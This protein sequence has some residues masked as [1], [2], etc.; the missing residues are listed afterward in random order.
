MPFHYR[1]DPGAEAAVHR[2]DG[3]PR[4][5]PARQLLAGGVP[6]VR[7]G[8]ELG[9]AFAAI[10]VIAEEDGVVHGDL[11]VDAVWITGDGAVSL[12]GYVPDGRRQS[13]AP[14]GVPRGPSTDRYGLGRLLARTLLANAAR[15]DEA[16]KTGA[17]A[18]DDA[19]AAMVM[20]A[21]VPGLADRTVNDLRWYI[22]HLLS[23]DRAERPEPLAVWQSLEAF[24]RTAAGP[25]LAAWATAAHR[26]QADVRGPMAPVVPDDT[27]AAPRARGAGLLSGVRFS[28][29]PSTTLFWKRDAAAANASDAAAP[30]TPAPSAGAD[31]GTGVPTSD[32]AS[33]PNASAVRAAPP[34]PGSRAR[35]TAEVHL[36][37]PEPGGGER[38]GHWS[39]GELRAM[40]REVAEGP[41]PRRDAPV[42]SDRAR[43]AASAVGT[44]R[45]ARSAAADR[46]P[47]A[48][49]VPV[50]SAAP[51]AGRRSLRERVGARVAEA[52]AMPQTPPA[53]T[54]AE[55]LAPSPSPG[56]RALHARRAEAE[57]AQPSTPV[58]RPGRVR[59]AVSEEE[60]DALP[61]SVVALLAVAVLAAAAMV[62]VLV[63]SLLGGGLA[64][65]PVA[66]SPLEAE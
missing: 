57:A 37:R 44:P 14:E 43:V 52:E 23:F 62:G 55:P 49:P 63:V 17:V 8:L 13:R 48:A 11:D 51:V 46:E 66:V 32:E 16:P 54:G 45:D 61:R 35:G 60:P 27:L 18:H 33:A 9:A 20:E 4:G 40:A 50:A 10:A 53:P 26:G 58:A 38:T 47:A 24:A 1:R 12:G 59:P 19:M 64:P 7:V 3:D 2:E 56:R 36:E 22:L 42:F 34:R 15:V 65:P 28:E 5:T 41:R 21:Q 30:P 25:S 39:I 29:E 6:P 31:G